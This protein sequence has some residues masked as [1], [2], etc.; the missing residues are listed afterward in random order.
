MQKIG[1]TGNIGSG[2][3]LAAKV[4]EQLKVPVFYAD[5]DGKKVLEDAWI[6]GLIKK[7]FGSGIMTGSEIDRKKLAQIVFADKAKLAFLNSIIHPAVRAQF[8]NWTE[9]KGDF[10]YIIY[11]AAILYESGHFKAM[12][13][14]IVVAA[15]EELRIKRVMQRDQVSRED[16]IKRMA[17]QWPEEKKIALA[18]FVIGNNEST[19]VIPQVLAIDQKLKESVS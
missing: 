16:V 2:K 1:L 17:N 19:L 8:N 11:E 13:K 6:I 7:E 3:S 9:Q 12:D 10:P 18:D 5:T 15:G 14:I 4:F